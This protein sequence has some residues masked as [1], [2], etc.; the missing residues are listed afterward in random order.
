MKRI[1]VGKRLVIGFELELKDK[2]QKAKHKSKSKSKSKARARASKEMGA[3]REGQPAV[4]GASMQSQEDVV[5]GIG[6]K[7]RPSGSDKRRFGDND[8]RYLRPR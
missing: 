5:R 4:E 6:G 3:V 1:G 7:K 2:E 8:G